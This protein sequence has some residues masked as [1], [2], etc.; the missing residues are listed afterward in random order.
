[1]VIL[2]KTGIYFYQTSNLQ[3]LSELN[4]QQSA[5]ISD[6]LF[7]TSYVSIPHRKYIEEEDRYLILLNIL[8]A[9]TD[10]RL[11]SYLVAIEEIEVEN[12]D[13]GNN[14]NNNNN[15]PSSNSFKVATPVTPN[16]PGGGHNSSFKIALNNN[17]T[18][19]SMET[20]I[21]SYQLSTC[22]FGYFELPGKV[23]YFCLSSSLIIS[24]H[25]NFF[26]LHLFSIFLV[27][28]DRFLSVPRRSESLSDHRCVI[29]RGGDYSLEK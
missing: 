8:L 12:P 2:E 20:T 9:G 1:V 3:L 19:D 27:P 26:F 28:S 16:A 23:F 11:Y 6:L 13:S 14:N 5:E 17:K 4:N 7:W 24:F 22:Y 18:N 15:I 29:L 25:Q 21:T 10:N